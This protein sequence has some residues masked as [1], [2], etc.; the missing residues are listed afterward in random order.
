[1]AILKYDAVIRFQLN[2]YKL[3]RMWGKFNR[4]NKTLR[5][6]IGKKIL[7]FRGDGYDILTTAGK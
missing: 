7:V 5:E 6:D 1:M 2:L 4:A 3:S